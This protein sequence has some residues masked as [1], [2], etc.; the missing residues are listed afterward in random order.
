MGFPPL[1]SVLF[2]SVNVGGMAM[3]SQNSVCC[4]SVPESNNSY[5]LKATLPSAGTYWYGKFFVNVTSDNTIFV[6]S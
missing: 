6:P 1:L 3:M 5:F 2:S 4:M